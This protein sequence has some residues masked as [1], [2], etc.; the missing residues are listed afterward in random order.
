MPPEAVVIALANDNA[1]IHSTLNTILTMTGYSTIISSLGRELEEIV[2]R[3]RPDLVLAH[4]SSRS[5]NA[6][7]EVINHMRA[8]PTTAAIPV[9]FYLKSGMKYSR[10]SRARSL[11]VSASGHFHALSVSMSVRRI[12]K[13][14][15]RC[16]RSSTCRTL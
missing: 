4:L 5:L 7:I 3:E 14:L 16:W 6:T 9:I 12:G 2:Q 11:P 1:V 8:N 15:R 13:S 10:T